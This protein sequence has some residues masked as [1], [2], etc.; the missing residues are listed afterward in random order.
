MKKFLSRITR[1]LQ[2]ATILPA[3][4][5][6]E[7]LARIEAQLARTGA[8]LDSLHR[9]E[10]QL[11]RNGAQLDFLNTHG[12]S[13]L[14][15]GI[16]L[17]HL[18]DETPI[19][20]N[21]NDFGSPM[22][23]LSGGR[24]EEDNLAVLLSFVD[25]STV[26][27]D[28]GANLGF[29][30]L[31]LAQR[32]RGGSGGVLAFEPQPRMLD[33]MRRS[34]HLNGLSDSVR[35]YPFAL[36][37]HEGTAIFEVPVGH[38]GG[39]HIPSS[40]T[41]RWQAKDAGPTERHEIPLRV[42]DDAVP[43]DFR[44]D[45][46]KIDVEGHELPALRGMRRALERSPNV[47]VLC[48]KMIRG[49]GDE[50][51]LWQFFTQLGMQLY[52]VGPEATLIPFR[53]PQDLI[54][55]DRG[56]IVASRDPALSGQRR[57]RR[58]SVYPRNLN[59]GGEARRVGEGRAATLEVSGR[60]ALVFG[61]YWSLPTGSWRLSLDGHV[62]QPIE[63]V[64][65]ERVGL[66][67]IARLRLQA[68]QSS[69]D[70][71]CDHDLVKF[72]CLLHALDMQLTRLHLTRINFER[73]DGSV[74]LAA[75]D[76]DAPQQIFTPPS[77]MLYLPDVPARTD[78]TA[79]AHARLP[80][81]FAVFSN[82]QGEVI[83]SA[84]QAFMG[85]R[86]PSVQ[87]V[88]QL[89]Y[90]NPELLVEPLRELAR[91]NDTILMQP[92]LAQH[93][94]P[95]LP[96]LADRIQLFP[97]LTFSAFHPD[98][99]YVFRGHGEYL[100]GPQ[101]P[102]HSS[103]AYHAWRVG[104][105]AAQAMN[106]FHDEVYEALHFHDYWDAS[107]RTLYAEGQAAN[108]PLESLLER[109]R[110][111]GC[112]MHTHNHPVLAP[113]VDITRALLVRAGLE[114][115]TVEPADFLHD[116][117]ASSPVWP[118]YPE[119]AARLG[120]TGS[121]SFK[122]SNGNQ[123]VRT[124]I[125]LIDL[126]E[127]VEQSFTAFASADPEQ[128]HCDR[129]YSARYAE[130]FGD[131]VRRQ[132]CIAIS[133]AVAASITPRPHPYSGLPAQQFW[134]SAVA[135]RAMAEVDPVLAPRFQIDRET[136]V[137][138]A[139][140]CFAQHIS[141]RLQQRGFGYLVTEPSPAGLDSGVAA[142]Q[143]YGVY[144]ARY[145]NLYT[146]RQLLQLHQ[147]AYGDLVPTE[148]AW[149]RPDGRLADPFRPEISP[150]GF[151][152]LDALLADRATHFT[153]VR[154][155]FET[156][157]VLVF[158]LGLTEAWRAKAD[159]AVFPLVPGVVAGEMDDAR[160]EFHNFDAAEVEADLEAFLTR[161]RERNP[162]VRLLLT[163]SPVPLVA[164]YEDRHVLTATTYSKAVLRVAAE[165]LVRRHADCDYFPA[166]EIVTGNFSRGAYYGADLRS[167]KPAGVDHVMRLFFAHYAPGA[168]SAAAEVD[169]ELLLEASNNFRIV[170]E[171]ER[172]D[173][174]G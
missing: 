24:Y 8:Q 99:C 26:F 150:D 21:S 95:L 68:G 1:R 32:L 89:A 159:G 31:R 86:M 80:P 125:R 71:H 138:T 45:L 3:G 158:T 114:L 9:I 28:I 161:L 4:G 118:V 167:I 37:D 165:A 14:G 10:H 146:A 29:F 97:S 49:Y 18:P 98:I 162:G 13:Y 46:V 142:G 121:Y 135:G 83:A 42:F 166:Y 168:E 34:L 110:V 87:A 151:A 62:D 67:E 35:I 120:C 173:S 51:G 91:H 59:T 11:A 70:F 65:K 106:Q 16:A 134:R 108:L 69:A 113:L 154:E 93:A 169:A 58:F 40:L 132:G 12:A 137:A 139:G 5:E 152:D 116:A 119:I 44:C 43:A 105:S 79:H 15:D 130:V 149:A 54:D 160:Y 122:A 144:S 140:S 143:N 61:P 7:R 147:R 76:A 164:T 22:N 103:I 109:W 56:Y 94:L 55:W 23:F 104:M 6:Q 112:F 145:G 111:R 2:S 33:L 66:L 60:E 63:I 127:F 17:T 25:D 131:P 129:P 126:E 19:F 107:A 155:M 78:Q 153:A 41:V 52:G 73:T 100:D 123:D 57:R 102:Y 136:R 157:Q 171:E 124:L 47:V 92:R 96:E 75:A 82:C 174:G 39:A 20:I 38:L 172:L 36:S 48:E 27:V 30:T 85:G 50:H 53:S 141:R 117:L 170:C 64:I 101:G 88:G 156:V 163:V 81:R 115:P 72:E 90:D 74:V 84:I 77:P 133:R 148:L 128:L